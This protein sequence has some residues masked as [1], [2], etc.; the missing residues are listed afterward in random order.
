MSKREVFGNFPG[1]CAMCEQIYWDRDNDKSLSA[2]GRGYMIVK[3]DDGKE[4]LCV[5]SMGTWKALSLLEI[6]QIVKH[7]DDILREKG[8]TVPFG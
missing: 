7:M 8:I 1:S 3:E 4:H 6:I 2:T 5:P